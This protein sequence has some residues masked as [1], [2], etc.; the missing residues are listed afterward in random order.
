MFKVAIIGGQNRNNYTEFESKCIYYLSR[1]AKNKEPIIILTTG[2]K[3]VEKFCQ[4]F[5]IP[6]RYFYADFK[7]YKRK[8]LNVRNEKLL[9]ECNAVIY[10][11]D[12]LKDSQDIYY[13]ALEKGIP[14]RFIQ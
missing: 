10:F 1:R 9:S 14:S 8:A 13:L 12:G 6:F 4:K 3:L 7:T 11:N 5:S 2:D